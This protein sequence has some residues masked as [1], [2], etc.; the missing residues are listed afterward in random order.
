MQQISKGYIYFDGNELKEVL[1][2]PKEVEFSD[3]KVDEEG[4]TLTVL[5]SEPIKVDKYE[6]TVPTSLYDNSIWKVNGFW[7][8]E[9]NQADKT[10]TGAEWVSGGSIK[11][12]GLINANKAAETTISGF[13]HCINSITK[14]I[15][16]ST[17]C[18]LR[19]TEFFVGDT[20]LDKVEYEL[21]KYGYK[22]ERV[23]VVNGSH[24]IR[25][26]W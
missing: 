2:L 5:S 1:G 10:N 4:V 17:R 23:K 21:I 9:V 7:L 18:G 26:G 24:L 22:V 15:Y 16:M 11:K 8:A 12:D 25:I 3:V 14:E 6:V 19:C 13:N 20:E